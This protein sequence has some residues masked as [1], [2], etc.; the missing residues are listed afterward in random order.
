MGSPSKF[1][2]LR[3]FP[4][5]SL[6]RR[7]FAI[8]APDSRTL[9]LAPLR[10][11]DKPENSKRNVINSKPTWSKSKTNTRRSAMSSSVPS[12]SSLDTKRSPCDSWLAPLPWEPIISLFL[13]CLIDH[14]ILL[15]SLI[16]RHHL[17]KKKKN[18]VIVS[19]ITR[20]DDNHCHNN[21]WHDDGRCCCRSCRQS[22]DDSFHGD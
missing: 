12:M 5:K 18:R 2:R 9:R 14:L 1:P 16:S 13:S 10:A 17:G 6:T 4:A 21:G 3:P 15:L 11:R 20:D 22:H 7:P 8:S 19:M